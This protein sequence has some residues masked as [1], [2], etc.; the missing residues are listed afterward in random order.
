MFR[1]MFELSPDTELTDQ[2]E[3]F[4][5]DNSSDDSLLSILNPFCINKNI[6]PTIIIE[7]ALQKETT[8]DPTKRRRIDHELGVPGKGKS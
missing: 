5:G 7:M 8:K 1:F 2:F 6:D 4:L 3:M